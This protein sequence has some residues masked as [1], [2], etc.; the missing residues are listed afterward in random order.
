MPEKKKEVLCRCG[1]V[2]VDCSKAVDQQQQN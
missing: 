2:D 1:E